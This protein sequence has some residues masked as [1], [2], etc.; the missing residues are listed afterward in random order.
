MIKIK[1]YIQELDSEIKEMKESQIISF[2]KRF[3]H[4]KGEYKSKIVYDLKFTAL[5]GN[6]IKI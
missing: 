6:G 2:R 4:M 1:S 3:D 5:F